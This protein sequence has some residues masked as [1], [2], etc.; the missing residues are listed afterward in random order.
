[1]GHLDL[2]RFH[3]PLKIALF[4][5]IQRELTN[6]KRNHQRCT[7]EADAENKLAKADIGWL[8]RWRWHS[9]DSAVRISLHWCS[10]RSVL[11]DLLL[12]PA[13]W[14]A[15]W[16]AG[17]RRSFCHDFLFFSFTSTLHHARG[18]TRACPI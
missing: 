8:H 18:V 13:R 15:G 16:A 4:V 6:Q 9:Y 1:M 11:E 17:K 14:A 3:P 2:E 10:L 5:I 7:K 12:P